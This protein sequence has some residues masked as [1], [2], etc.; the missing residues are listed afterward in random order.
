MFLIVCGPFFLGG[1]P[2][3]KGVCILNIFYRI[4]HFNSKWRMKHLALFVVGAASLRPTRCKQNS[5][6][7]F[8]AF[9]EFPP[10]AC[11]KAFMSRTSHDFW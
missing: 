7:F 1:L 2:H 9:S 3:T 11:E 4:S 10:N 6:I 8:S 5:R